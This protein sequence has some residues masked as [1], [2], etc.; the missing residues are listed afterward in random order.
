MG[1]LIAAGAGLLCGTLSG[2]GVGGGTL[3]MVW[4]TAIMGM[5]Q[6]MA[7]GINLL[8]FLPTAILALIFHIRNRLICWRIVL[9]AA[10]AGCLTAACTAWLSTQ[11]ET[12]LLRRLFGIFLLLIGI[13]EL[14]HRPKG[15]GADAA[16]VC[17]EG[18]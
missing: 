16:D 11:M 13:C 5:E 12:A 1:W 7:Q 2:L 18:N 15:D 10:V 14:F 17:A 8:Y 3:L 6:Q 4:L 9:P